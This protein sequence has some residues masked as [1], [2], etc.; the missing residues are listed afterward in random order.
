LDLRGL[1]LRRG[2]LSLDFLSCLMS[3]RTEVDVGWK[4]EMET[5]L[6]LKSKIQNTKQLIK[7]GKLN[8]WS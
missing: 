5:T 8:N 2:I 1:L 6:F 7:Y 4:A 3:P